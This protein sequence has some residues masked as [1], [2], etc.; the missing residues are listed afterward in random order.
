M[1]WGLAGVRGGDGGM[2]GGREGFPA[3]WRVLCR[4]V[5]QAK[6]HVP[7][8]A[9]GLQGMVWRVAECWA[10]F[11]LVVPSHASPLI[12]DVNS[13]YGNISLRFAE[14]NPVS[15]VSPVVVSELREM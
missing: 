5:P 14:I 8:G 4:A 3:G 15:V 11:K 7:P 2:E 12:A 9:E 6:L 1:G 13:N 10:C